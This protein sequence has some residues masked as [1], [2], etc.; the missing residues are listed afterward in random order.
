MGKRNGS[1]WKKMRRRGGEEEQDRFNQ[2][3]EL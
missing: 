2:E 3:K 1:K